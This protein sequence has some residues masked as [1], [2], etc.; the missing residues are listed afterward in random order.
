[1]KPRKKRDDQENSSIPTELSVSL[2]E[3]PE[4][5]IVAE[6]PPAPKELTT[7]QKV[8]LMGDLA[9]VLGDAKVLEAIKSLPSG[10]TILEIFTLAIEKRLNEIMTNKQ[11]TEKETG[12]LLAVARTLKEDHAKFSD[13]LRMFFNSELVQVLG[14]LA[15]N[16]AN[17]STAGQMP[18]QQEEQQLPP[19]QQPQR[20]P[21][22]TAQGPYVG[23][24]SL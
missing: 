4:E 24:G 1:M 3:V 19:P 16:M 14:I 11:E 2:T 7:L 18:N 15:K 9:N 22:Q 5:K 20:Q 21:T 17:R 6:A 12:M 8:K 13:Y 10:D 23:L